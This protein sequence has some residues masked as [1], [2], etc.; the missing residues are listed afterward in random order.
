M[1]AESGSEPTELPENAIVV[2]QKESRLA[3]ECGDVA[4]RTFTQSSAG[5]SVTLQCTIRRVL[6]SITMK[7]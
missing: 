4:D 5:L 2:V 7:T 6:I 1:A 3:I